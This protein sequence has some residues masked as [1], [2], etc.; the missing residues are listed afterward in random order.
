VLTPSHQATSSRAGVYS[1]ASA[2]P[3]LDVDAQ[4]H[5]P[6]ANLYMRLC[7]LSHTL[8]MILS[9]DVH[10]GQSASRSIELDS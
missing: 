10:A 8:D 1:A 4:P 9:T 7:A 3:T 2:D 6:T 5:S